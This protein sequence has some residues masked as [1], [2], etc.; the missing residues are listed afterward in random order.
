MGGAP[1]MADSYLERRGPARVRAAAELL[2][3]A[4]KAL[5]GLEKA[6]SEPGSPAAVL[7]PTLE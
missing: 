7:L 4:S 3:Q 5:E 1:Q 6:A 2:L